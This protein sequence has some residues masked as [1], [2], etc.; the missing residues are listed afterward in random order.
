MQATDI[1]QHICIEK[2]KKL[3]LLVQNVLDF[4]EGQ[5]SLR[6]DLHRESVAFFSNTNLASKE[7]LSVS[8][9]ALLKNLD[10]ICGYLGFV[11]QLPCLKDVKVDI[12]EAS[13]K[14]IAEHL[15]SLLGGAASHVSDLPSNAHHEI[16]EKSNTAD[17]SDRILSK[18]QKDL[19]PNPLSDRQ[20]FI[21]RFAGS[22]KKFQLKE[23][24]S[25]FPSLSEKTIRNDLLALCDHGLVQRYGKAPRS[26][27]EITVHA[28][29][30]SCGT[31]QILEHTES[32]VFSTEPS[33]AIRN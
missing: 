21:L 28:E 11:R 4:V 17:L 30:V 26:Y 5:D 3:T 2:I 13:Y 22:H 1:A 24:I 25:H 7:A 6:A 8:P 10:N 12:L 29:S 20:Q 23:L 33:Q 27:Y 31:E 14:G 19:A 15:A 9:E 18:A 32:F 16:S